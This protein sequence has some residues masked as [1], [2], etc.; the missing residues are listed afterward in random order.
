M[1]KLDRPRHVDGGT[2]HYWP[3]HR[4]I[5]LMGPTLVRRPVLKLSKDAE[6]LGDPKKPKVA[7]YIWAQ[8]WF[9]APDKEEPTWGEEQPNISFNH[10]FRGI[11][12]DVSRH[13]GAVGNRSAV[14]AIAISFGRWTPTV[15]VVRRMTTSLRN[16]ERE[17]HLQTTR[18]SSTRLPTSTMDVPSTNCAAAIR[19]IS[20]LAT[21]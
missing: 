12:I 21:A 15:P 4:P 3:V 14:R 16:V 1:A 6:G 19:I 13:A 5:L 7:V 11:D 2:Q 18:R 8:T 17:A 10:V 20:C 9:D